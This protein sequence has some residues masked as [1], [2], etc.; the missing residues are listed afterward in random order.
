MNIGFRGQSLKM[1]LFLTWNSLTSTFLAFAN[2]DARRN[3]DTYH[4]QNNYFS[5][6]R[7]YLLGNSETCRTEIIQKLGIGFHD[8]EN[9]SLLLIFD[10]NNT[11]NESCQWVSEADLKYIYIYIYFGRKD[12]IKQHFYLFCL[13]AWWYVLSDGFKILKGGWGR[14]CSA[15]DACIVWQ[16]ICKT[17]F[18]PKR[19]FI[20]W[21]PVR[22]RG[23]TRNKILL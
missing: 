16:K 6:T 23:A 22:R 18:T 10:G 13:L 19:F 12:K 2:K 8:N 9:L 3:L 14:V 17:I 21:R 5:F 20:K 1:A 7:R 11:I 4:Q 15:G